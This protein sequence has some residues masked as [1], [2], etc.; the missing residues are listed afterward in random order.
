[1]KDTRAV[2]WC[3][4]WCVWGEISSLSSVKCW[5][6]T[7]ECTYKRGAAGVRVTNEWVCRKFPHKIFKCDQE[8]LKISSRECLHSFQCSSSTRVLR[9]L[10]LARRRRRSH[11]NYSNEIFSTFKL[12][13]YAWKNVEE[14]SPSD[15]SFSADFEWDHLLVRL[16]TLS[17]VEM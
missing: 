2:S 13:I 9:S 7:C 1:M 5:S 8:V 4:M 16:D 10:W 11:F 12:W 14:F 3:D 17:V 6:M 15:M